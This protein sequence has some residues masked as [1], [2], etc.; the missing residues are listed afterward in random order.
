MQDSDENRNGQPQRPKLE[1]QCQ[2][3][4]MSC[5]TPKH[6]IWHKVNSKHQSIQFDLNF[7][8]RE[9]RLTGLLNSIY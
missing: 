9:M 5:R 3:T 2:G 4:F 6:Y 8:T 1:P 7:C